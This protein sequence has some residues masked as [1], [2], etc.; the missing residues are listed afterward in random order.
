MKISVWFTMCVVLLVSVG[1]VDLFAQSG[2]TGG[3][4]ITFGRSSG[5]AVVGLPDGRQLIRTSN[6][7]INL[8]DGGGPFHLNTQDCRGTI[9]MVDG[10][11]RN[12]GY[13]DSVD[14]D[15]DVWWLSYTN[16]LD[17]GTFQIL[18][19]TGK[20]AGIEGG[21]TTRV[22]GNYDD[23]RLVLRWDGNWQMQ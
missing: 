2:T 16:D 15:G 11:V 12:Y 14:A 4:T 7:G 21:G 6:S 20:F 18:G 3:G 17:S 22:L 1:V 8:A 5:R 13:C 19:G 23:G 9:V 10:G